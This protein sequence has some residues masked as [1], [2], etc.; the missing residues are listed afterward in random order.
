M[1]KLFIMLMVGLTISTAAVSCKG[2][3][4][5]NIIRTDK[6]IAYDIAANYTSD[7]KIEIRRTNGKV[8]NYYV[9][10][11][12]GNY[13]YVDQYSPE[14]K[15]ILTSKGVDYYDAMSVFAELPQ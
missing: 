12:V 1:K 9:S 7:A 8:D 10:Y 2:E 5:E 13:T 4:P 6:Q 3:E 14:G 11:E 15:R